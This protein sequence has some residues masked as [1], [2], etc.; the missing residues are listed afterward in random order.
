MNRIECMNTRQA[1]EVRRF[2]D[3]RHVRYNILRANGRI[4]YLP[5]SHIPAEDMDVVESLIGLNR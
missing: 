4:V 2:L 3:M 5:K 1:R